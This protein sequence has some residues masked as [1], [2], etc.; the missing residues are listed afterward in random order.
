MIFFLSVMINPFEKY[1][2]LKLIIISTRN[3][4]PEQY[5]NAANPENE[6][7]ETFNGIMK[8]FV[9][10]KQNMRIFQPMRK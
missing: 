1:A 9:R 5:V 4:H 6:E 2:E 8:K 3:K 10:S 7:Y